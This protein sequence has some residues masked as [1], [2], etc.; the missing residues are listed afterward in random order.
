MP[1][2][3]ILVLFAESAFTDALLMA[4]NEYIRYL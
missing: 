1:S 2:R 3:F 4:S